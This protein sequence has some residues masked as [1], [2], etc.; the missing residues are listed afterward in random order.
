MSDKSVFK[1]PTGA[2]EYG[3]PTIINAL[4]DELFDVQLRG[5]N[6]LYNGAWLLDQVNE[7]ALY[8]INSGST[9][10]VDGWTGNAVGAGVFK[11][12]RLADPDFPSLTCLEITCT[13]ADAAIAAGDLYSL[14]A[15]IEGYDTVDLLSGTA[16]AKQITISFPMK[17][18]VAGVYGIRLSN[19]SANRSYVGTV[20]Q[21]V[22]NTRED[23]TVT[24][25]LD[26]AGT[27]AGADNTTGLR[28]DFTLAAG[29]TYHGTAGWQAGVF[30][31]TSA[32]CNFM[33]STANIGYLGRIKLEQGAFAT[34]WHPDDMDYAKVL[35]KGRECFRF[36][37]AGLSGVVDSS[38][39]VWFGLPIDP[40]MRATPTIS[41]IST[42]TPSVRIGSG[43]ASGSG[44]TIAFSEAAIDGASIQVDGFTGLTSGDSVVLRT[45]KIVSLNARLS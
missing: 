1:P 33:S 19:N 37:P 31:T 23:K 27:W 3:Y 16:S 25:T 15:N 29:S 5:K 17:F 41:A 35:A 32:Q 34:P 20:T 8:T 4:V 39:T 14:N 28:L 45:S 42:A 21:D 2:T 18:S 11:V 38:T 7:G 43:N 24:L 26:T 44:S 10:T 30:V 9:Q 13:T 36:A 6:F 22:A 12:R 40:P